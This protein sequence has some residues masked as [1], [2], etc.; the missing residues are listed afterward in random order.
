MFLDFVRLLTTTDS[1]QEM[2]KT[3]KA[4]SLYELSEKFAIQLIDICGKENCKLPGGWFVTMGVNDAGE[5]RKVFSY[6]WGEGGKNYKANRAFTISHDI[7]HKQMHYGFHKTEKF[8][9]AKEL[10]NTYAELCI[11][12]KEVCLLESEDQ[13][14]Q[15]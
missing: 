11:S 7:L 13:R 5:E 4:N 2:V 1:F 3:P 9:L 15:R 6:D 14:V 8:E 12:L 10:M